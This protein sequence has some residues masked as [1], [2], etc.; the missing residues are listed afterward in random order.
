MEAIQELDVENDGFPEFPIQDESED[1]QIVSEQEY[2]D[3]Y[4]IH[5]YHSYE[6][7]NGRLEER[8]MTNPQSYVMYKWFFKLLD[9]FLEIH[10]IGMTMGLD[11]GFRL[12]LPG[13]AM[14]RKPDLALILNSNPVQPGG[15]E[16]SY[17]GIFDLCIESLSHSNTEVILRDTVIKKNEYEIVGVDEYYILDSRG[18]ETAFYRRGRQGYE[19]I[20]P[21]EGVIQ[22][23]VLRGFRF[24]VSDLYMCPSMHEMAEDNLYT[25]FVLPFYTKEK[26]RAEQEEQKAG[27]M[28]EKLRSLGISEEE[29][30]SLSEIS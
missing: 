6:W 28:A 23:E 19:Y 3:H 4:Y 16:A 10:P 18:K 29:I 24:R 11:F 14:V 25:D 1:G 7:N 21:I 15:S 12:A 20:E 17:K 22:S 13:K 2:W 26:R 27:R 30:K 9:L 8:P 5:P